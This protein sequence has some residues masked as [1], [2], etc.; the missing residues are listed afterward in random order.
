MSDS[1]Q[2]PPGPT[3]P[4]YT[5]P[6]PV[7]P[8]P[9]VW[10]PPP[11]APPPAWGPPPGPVGPPSGPPAAGDPQG[12]GAPQ[13][14]HKPSSARW[15][16]IGLAVVVVLA[17][18]AGGATF[19]LLRSS[20]GDDSVSTGSGS[21]SA[22]GPS[23]GSTGSRAE[24]GQLP[25]GVDDVDIVGGDPDADS[26][27]AMQIAI[28]DVDAYWARTYP[29]VFGGRY[30]T[31]A[32]GFYAANDGQT[33]PCATDA[34]EVDGN[35]YYCPTEDVVAWD[36]DGLVPYMVDTYGSLG[37]GLVVAH[38][39]GHA[40]QVRAGVEG[41]TVFLEQQADCL[42]GAWVD[43]VRSDG[44]RWFSVDG[45]SLDLAMAGFL[46]LRDAPGSVATDPTAHG[47]AFDR[48][49]AFQEG[50]DGGAAACADYTLDTLTPK[51][52]D[53]PFTS[54]EE[55]ASGGN[56]PLQ[57]AFDLTVADLEDFWSKA[58]PEFGSGQFDPPEVE[59]FSSSERPDCDEPVGLSDE[60]FYCPD[61][62][63]LAV[64]DDGLV[65]KVH[66][67]IGDYALSAI[68]GS[69][70]GLAA[71]DGM[72]ELGDQSSATTRRADCLAGVWSASV[73]AQNRESAQLVLSPGDLDEAVAALLTTADPG[74]DSVT[75]TG[76]ER[77][78][79]YRSGFMEGRDACRP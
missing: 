41:P 59:I 6:A 50:V 74:K 26:Q 51:L 13:P 32:G 29:E 42:A 58:W 1:P 3:P 14:P 33:P 71:L 56:L 4:P 31:V 47:T 44:D 62:N 55:V 72:D 43:D 52:V 8:A 48:I 39:W 60:V 35:A 65:V 61:S 46:E 20:D 49:R 70:Y 78:D 57:E 45:E 24:T 15:L 36:A 37:L 7:P 30:S 40:I 38:E 76:F 77:V 11:A 64:Q 17:L 2:S 10:G 53:L 68:V 54:Q 18:I 28:A 23:L 25:A 21:G 66:K 19:A 16:L 12:W 9:P 63:L 79:A 73:F 34:S 5:P 22:D 69:G 27:R 75:G 67:A